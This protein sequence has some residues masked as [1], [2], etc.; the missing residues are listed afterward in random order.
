MTAVS[1]ICKN[2]LDTA[3]RLNL[4]TTAAKLK[5]DLYILILYTKIY[6]NNAIHRK[7]YPSSFCISPNVKLR[8]TALTIS[9]GYYC[10]M[11]LTDIRRYSNNYDS[12]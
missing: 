7:L 2:I 4:V 3:V 9:L 8:M 5:Q 6:N 12:E 11:F 10:F 1:V